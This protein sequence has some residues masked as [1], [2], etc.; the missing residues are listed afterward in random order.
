VNVVLVTLYEYSR[1]QIGTS[2]SWQMEMEYDHNFEKKGR[3]P[4]CSGKMEDNLNVKL[5]G[6]QFQ[7]FYFFGKRK[8]KQGKCL[9][10]LDLKP[11]QI[12][13][14]SIMFKAT[15]KANFQFITK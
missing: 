8:I 10:F 6:R 14:G 5:N 11:N 1:I 13:L 9:W 2:I 15:Y 4:H 3:Q 7:F 12:A